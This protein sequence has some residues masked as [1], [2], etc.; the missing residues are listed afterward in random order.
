MAP[1]G[2]PE[3]VGETAGNAADAAALA[4]PL[5]AVVREVA[6]ELRRG[7]SAPVSGGLDASLERDFGLDSL[8]RV[9]LFAR[10]ERTLGARLDEA[11]ISEAETPRDLLR[12][13]EIVAPRDASAPAAPASAA[14]AAALETGPESA[15]TIIE[16]LEWHVAVHPD[17]VHIY[18]YED[19]D[20][21]QAITYAALLADAR[22]V[23]RGLRARDVAPGDRV[24]M[25]LPTGRDFLAAFYGAMYAGCV[26]VPVYPPA[27][28]SQ[29]E[30]HLRRVA[31]IV[32]NAQAAVLVSFEQARSVAGLLKM[33]GLSSLAIETVADLSRR[34]LSGFDAGAD[35]A[36]GF[37]QAHDL[38]FLQYTSGSTGEPKGVELT[39]HNLLVNLASM[40]EA[41]GVH[42]RDV[43]VSWLPLYHDM[44]LIGAVM[45]SLTIGFTL[46]LMSPLAFLARPARW[47]RAVHRHRGTITAAPNFAYEFCMS[48]IDERDLAGIDLR[49][50][51][52]AFNGAETVMPSTIERFA[53]RFA[54]YGLRPEALTPVYGLAE[55]TLGVAFPPIGRGPRIERIDRAQM[56]E[57]ERAVPAADGDPN[58]L[59]IVGCGM[60][61]PGHDIRA[62][63][64]AGRELPERHQGRI[65]FRGPSST[66][67]YFRRPDL[68]AQLC[69]GDWRHTGDLGYLADGELFLAGRAKDII[70]RGG[71][72]I[73]PQELEDAVSGVAGVRKGGVCVF[74]VADEASGT[75]RLVVLVETS[76]SGSEERERI[77]ERIR[78]LSVDL[79]GTPADEIVLAPPRSVLKTSSGK[80]RRSACRELYEAGQIGHGVRPAWV[81]MLRLA[82]RGAVRQTTRLVRGVTGYAWA[83][84]VWA[85]FALVFVVGALL[86]LVLPGLALRRALS[87]WIVRTALWLSGLPVKIDGAEHLAGE[88]PRIIAANH[89]SYVDW[90]VLGAVLPGRFSFVAKEELSRTFLL[91]TLLRRMGTSFVERF[92]AAQG[93]DDTRRMEER[94]RAGASL[95][96]F[97]EGTFVRKSG[98]LPLRMGAFVL[99]ARTA[100]PIIPVALR[101]TR[102][103][104]RA[105]EW[106]PRRTPV[107][108]TVFAAIAPQGAD[109]AGA[110][111]LRA[112]VHERLREGSREPDAR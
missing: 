76:A 25:M 70:I 82:A 39:H 74:P 69:D 17:R 103:V 65:Q 63:D 100:T 9:E 95:A 87:R 51:R 33:Q 88:A 49:C 66:A 71:H 48:K 50:L 106:F 20:E 52:F 77:S 19:G 43:F 80:I 34:P 55:A 12:Y 85:L 45:G 81:Q 83:A 108:V 79:L 36:R 27:R 8:A 42:A 93:I 22:A 104:L 46:V 13:I 35:D 86:I 73:H 101:G 24:A 1:T 75:E 105:D 97:P 99:A 67:G 72:N 84:W 102:S 107:R 2:T 26:P 59:R 56:R 16:V 30:D 29:L 94:L 47:L 110:I 98:M 18:L 28:P 14:V 60:P 58:P 41:T 32:A 57:A 6:G 96:V 11:A 90:L 15:R 5:L 78:S 31:A 23:A 91:S 92:D 3:A 64:D 10:L 7:A 21:P 109:W 112:A 44:G 53:E 54:P 62:I 40:R 111:E 61:L 4:E 37:A 38:A 68:S 89:A